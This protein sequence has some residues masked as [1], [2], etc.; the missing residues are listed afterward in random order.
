MFFNNDGLFPVAPFPQERTSPIPKE[1]KV[2]YPS[3]DD[4]NEKNFGVLE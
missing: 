1:P 3:K 4:K 2:I